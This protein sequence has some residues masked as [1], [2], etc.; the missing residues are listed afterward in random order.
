M[1]SLL[2]SFDKTRMNECTDRCIMNFNNSTFTRGELSCFNRYAFLDLDAQG[3]FLNSS[4]E[5]RGLELIQKK[6]I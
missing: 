4:P 5:S 3:T 1:D 6:S 2:T